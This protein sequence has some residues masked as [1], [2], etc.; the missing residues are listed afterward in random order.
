[1]IG[2][3]IGTWVIE[4]EVGR[5]PMGT[6]YKARSADFAGEQPAVAA[7]K[8]LTHPLT[9]EA[10]FQARFPAE[11]LALR[12]LSHPNVARF[13]DSG[14]HAGLAYYATEFVDGTDCGTLLRQRE[15]TAGTPGLSWR[16]EILSIAAQA[17]RGLKHGHHR[18]LLHRDLKP[19][20]LV[21]TRDGLLKLTDFGVAKVYNLAPLALPGD[22]TGT[23]GYL[24]PEHFT[25]KPLT[26]RSDLYALGGVLYTLLAGR[27]PFAAATAAEFMHKHCYMLP[28]RP[29]NF[30]PKLPPE[31]DELV[32]E[33]L[34]KDPGRRPAS[35][36]AFLDEL[37]RVRG[38]LE[39][40]GE[41]IVYP[42]DP[43]D[44]TGTHA[45]LPA[46][47]GGAA[48][49]DRA[50]RRERLLKA[51]GLLA[52]L[53]LVVGAILFA[54]F[55]PRPPADE[56]WAAAQPL[57]RSDD[58][59]AWDKAIDDYLDPLTRWHPDQYAAEVKEARATI[60]AR[61][62]LHKLVVQGASDRYRSEAERLYYRGLRQA[63]AGDWA[64]ARATWEAVA[65]AF[66]RVGAERSW[67]ELARD[68]LAELGR[69]T[70][71]AP[72][73][74]RAARAVDAVVAEAEKLRAAGQGAVA[75]SM[76]EELDRLYADRPDVQARIRQARTPAGR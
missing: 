57:L 67:A 13:Y 52:L 16:E 5:G 35:A 76:L 29:A 30:V 56:L 51:A 19:S 21:L 48:G 6:V 53:L 66:G 54:F 69:R 38:K 22:P 12:R 71:P 65:G 70:P 11:M 72:D 75:D 74:G 37:D 36:A 17:A 61:K 50:E 43:G 59:A 41:R 73:P 18:S 64:A 14:V 7:V 49:A 40:K 23:A 46:A 9:Q 42:P 62:E 20:N 26:R 34:A 33:L 44:P 27:P 31:V 47:A 63:Q 45:A 24:A 15:K 39:R 58:P 68:G 1:M 4:A 3:R 25:G 55:R 8:L 60:A 28:D 10:A 2:T 32:C